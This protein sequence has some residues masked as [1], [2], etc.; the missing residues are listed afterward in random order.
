MGTCAPIT[1]D[2]VVDKW[3]RLAWSAANRYAVKAGDITADDLW[4]AAVM[5][6]WRAWPRFD[7]TRTALKVFVWHAA[8]GAMMHERRALNRTR[9][10][11]VSLDNLSDS[12]AD[13]LR[14]MVDPSPSVED[15]VI[16]ADAAARLWAAVDELGGRQTDV[17]KRH[18]M[19]RETYRVIAA[20]WAVNGRT[21][22]YHRRAA[23]NAL[24]R[25]E[26]WNR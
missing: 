25:R 23:L 18:Y 10:H 4:T 16:E 13:K 9:R 21:V 24:A 14:V 12:D 22:Q 15:I 11:L 7:C 8:W 3:G 17:I 2:E 1:L 20:A 19:A 5:G 6:I 26:G